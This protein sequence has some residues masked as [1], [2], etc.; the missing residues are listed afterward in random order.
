MTD[1]GKVYCIDC[2]YKNINSLIGIELATCRTKPLEIKPKELKWLGEWQTKV[3]KHQFR[4]SDR[5]K[6]NDCPYFKPDIFSRLFDKR[7]RG[8]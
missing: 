6:D 2:K 1:K 4:C 7:G 8:V 5:N 3:Q